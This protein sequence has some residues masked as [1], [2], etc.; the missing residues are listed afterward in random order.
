MSYVELGDLER[1]KNPDPT[2][3]DCVRKHLSQAAVLMDEARQGY[4]EHVWLAIGNLAEAARESAVRYPLL[5]AKIR[6][7][8]HKLQKNPKHLVPFF[9]L[10]EEASK[11]ASGRKQ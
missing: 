7:Q 2:C 9:A 10:I 4:P 8:R 1:A 6:D 11:Y 3:L 5:A